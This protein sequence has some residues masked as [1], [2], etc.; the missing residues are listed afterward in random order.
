MK[1]YNEYTSQLVG[2]SVETI[3]TDK[4]KLSLYKKSSNSDIPVSILEEV[5]RRGYTIWNDKFGGTPEQFAFDRVNSFIAGGFAAQLDEDLLDKKRGLWD[6]IH[7]KRARIK[8]GS[9]ERMRKPG[10]K[11]A[12]T[13]AAL[14]ASQNE[15]ADPC[16]TGYKQVGMKT[17][18]GKKVPNCV[19]VKEEELNKKVM[20]PEQIA[21]KHGVSV[22]SINKCLKRGIQVEKEHTTHAEEAR[23]I[24]LA[25][26]GE[27][28]NYYKKL[29]KAGLEED[30][31]AH[32]KDFRKPSSRFIGSNELVDI[33]KSQTPG[34]IIK[35]VIREHLQEV[36]MAMPPAVTP[37]AIVGQVRPGVRV[38]PRPTEVSGRA[39]GRISGQTG[40]MS[41]RPNVKVTSGVQPSIERSWKTSGR[42]SV[43]TGGGS[44]SATP[45]V[46]TSYSQ[47]GVNVGKGM[48][49]S[50]QTSPVV[51]GMTDAGR[52]AVAGVE[53][54]APTLTKGLGTVARIATG[55]AATA[56]MAVMSP[57]PA[58]AGEDEKKRQETLKSY[59]PYKAS[60]RSVSDYEKQTL[61]PQKYEAPKAPAAPKV[62]APTP[63]SRPEFFSRGE[64]FKAAREKAGGSEG[65]FKYDNKTFQT[66]VPGEK[67]IAPEKQ[68]Q[69]GIE[70]ES[71]GKTLKKI[72][73]AISEAT[74]KG[75]TVPLN[76]PMKGDVKKSKV[77][78]DPDGDGKAQ[79]VNF[80]DKNMSIKK[81]QPARKRSYC[82][83]SGG[84]SGTNDKTS[85]NY[86]SRRAW[87][88]EETD[89][90][91]GAE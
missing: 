53:K 91:N 66:N 28:P 36:A 73:E 26:L 35:K 4:A 89:S 64:A 7:A 16:W 88:C 71:G 24:A 80:G 33:Y 69:T 27:D 72:K 34:Q 40:S 9:G 51:K 79:K 75:K 47:G 23:R 15:D 57:T 43:G 50:K 55:P 37:P 59:N 3:L 17:K 58:G 21:D 61:T 56:A 2:E 82:A 76:K 62:D 10:S 38:A 1:K 65:Q 11:G 87:N 85:A 44:M 52:S 12:P 70:A 5:Y 68:K 81:D 41:A 31:E 39:A 45:K 42:A 84:I 32:S 13:D 30:A 90:E 63:P 46:S 22:E 18:G 6:N 54:A 8:A 83:R 86:W 25:H 29:D 49:A 14:K 78:V 20:T 48:A 67:Y 74:Y 77:F 19:P 60:G